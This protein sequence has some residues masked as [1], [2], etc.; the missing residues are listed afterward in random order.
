M[1]LGSTATLSARGRGRELQVGARTKKIEIRRFVND[2]LIQYLQVH[3]SPDSLER[4]N[5][6]QSVT[7][8]ISKYTQRELSW[9]NIDTTEFWNLAVS[10]PLALSCKSEVESDK[11][12]FMQADGAKRMDSF[13]SFMQ[14]H[15]SETSKCS[16]TL[17]KSPFGSE[18]CTSS[19]I[20]TES[21]QMVTD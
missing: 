12:S 17:V 15:F 20:Q 8:T 5:Q 1:V 10:R 18:L 6:S 3:S 4:T 19:C 13:T 14:K 2:S 11:T 7:T 16:L 9:I 21:Q